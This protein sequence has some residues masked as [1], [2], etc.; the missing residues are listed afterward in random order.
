MNGL[1]SMDILVSE[2]S[3]IFAKM[4]DFCQ[5]YE[6][7]MIKLTAAYGCRIIKNLLK[8]LSKVAMSHILLVFDN[9]NKKQPYFIINFKFRISRG[10]RPFGPSCPVLPSY[11]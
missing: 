10:N 9:M 4:M 1:I 6:I 7:L 3:A 11:Y 8:W 5:N 2:V